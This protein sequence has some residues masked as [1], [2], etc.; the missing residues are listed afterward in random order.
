MSLNI[1]NRE[2]HALAARL[3]Q[4]TGETLTEAVESLCERDWRVWINPKTSTRRFIG[5]SGLSPQTAAS[6]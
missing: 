6:T 3:A 2:A 5:S 4:K 1:K